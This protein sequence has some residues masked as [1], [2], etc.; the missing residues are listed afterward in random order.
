MP[1][2]N[3]ETEHVNIT[4]PIGMKARAKEYGV[5]MSYHAAKAIRKAIDIQEKANA[6]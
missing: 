5:N 1:K 2:L 6:E 4:L 3:K